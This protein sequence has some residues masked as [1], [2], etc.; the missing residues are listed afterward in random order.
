MYSNGTTYVDLLLFTEA[1]ISLCLYNSCLLLPCGSSADSGRSQFNSKNAS[2]HACILQTIFSVLRDT[3]SLCW[4]YVRLNAAAWRYTEI[5]G[6]S[7]KFKTIHLV[8]LIVL[9]Y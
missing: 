6:I 3:V 7:N 1:A 8:I 2:Q 5:V 4:L 9:I